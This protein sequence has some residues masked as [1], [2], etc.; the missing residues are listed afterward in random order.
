MDGHLVKFGIP[1]DKSIRDPCHSSV[2]TELSPITASERQP[3]AET[4]Q[5]LPNSGRDA[6]VPPLVSFVL[7]RE[8]G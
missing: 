3:K 6:V 4:E 8:S 2:I 5:D 7:S 1:K